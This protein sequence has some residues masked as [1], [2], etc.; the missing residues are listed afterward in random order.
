MHSDRWHAAQQY[1]AA[2]KLEDKARKAEKVAN[3]EALVGRNTRKIVA[4]MTAELRQDDGSG[5]TASPEATTSSASSE[6]AFLPLPI[7]KAAEE[8]HVFRAFFSVEVQIRA[9]HG[10]EPT[11]TRALEHCTWTKTITTPDT[12]PLAVG[13]GP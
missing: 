5:T 12:V 6:V 11:S 2:E 10:Q 13:A 8:Q 4:Q 9:D 7:R 3:L 1:W